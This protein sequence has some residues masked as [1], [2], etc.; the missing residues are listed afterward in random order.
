ML[1]NHKSMRHRAHKIYNDKIIVSKAKV[2]FIVISCLCFVYHCH[3]LYMQKLRD[4]EQQRLAALKAAAKRTKKPDTTLWKSLTKHIVPKI[5]AACSSPLQDGE[6]DHGAF[7]AVCKSRC[8]CYI[9]NT[10]AQTDPIASHYPPVT[11]TLLCII[12][13]NTC[14]WSVI[15]AEFGEYNI[16]FFPCPHCAIW[17][18][19]MCCGKINYMKIHTSLCQGNIS[20]RHIR[21]DTSGASVAR[22]GASV[23]RASASVAR[24]SVH[25]SGEN[26]P[27]S[28]EGVRI[29]NA[30]ATAGGVDQVHAHRL[31]V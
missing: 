18:C 12:T 28:A 19:S 30:I 29:L 10:H 27:N 14:R 31:Y 23:A 24:A 6:I 17:I 22:T 3:V 9:Y 8:A 16:S 13:I 21:M 4:Q 20:H 11:L 1:L 2:L 7:C 15:S 5:Q 26:T 25:T